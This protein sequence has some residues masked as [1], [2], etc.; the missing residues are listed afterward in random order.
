MAEPIRSGAF[1]ARTFRPSILEFPDAR[2]RRQAA[3]VDV[4][5]E[6]LAALAGELLGRVQGDEVLGL[7]A[8]QI[9]EL[10]RVLVIRPTFDLDAPRVYVNP[11]ITARRGL[12]FVEERCLSLPGVAGTVRRAMAVDVVAQ[13]LEGTRF[14]TR[15]EAMDAVCLQHELDH[16][17]GVLFV[18]RL[19]FFRRRRFRREERDATTA[20]LGG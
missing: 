20:T 1:A 17:D 6:D 8:P 5:D 12:G 10:R 16:L 2:L 14:E 7:A 3:P 19:S 13:D 18:D 15:L 11:E 4:F 9:D